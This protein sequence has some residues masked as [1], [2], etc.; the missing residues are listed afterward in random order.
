MDTNMTRRRLLQLLVGS[1]GAVG[2]GPLAQS[3]ENLT[4]HQAKTLLPSKLSEILPHRKSASAVGREYLKIAPLE[5][6]VSRLL[7]LIGAPEKS[8]RDRSSADAEAL[9]EWLQAKQRD[10]FDQGRIVLVQ[11]WMLSQTEARLCALIALS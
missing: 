3:A 1:L 11:R 9:A 4:R 7:E 5:A 8:I 6:D 10:D 2:V